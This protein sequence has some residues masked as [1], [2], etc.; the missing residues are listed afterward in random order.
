MGSAGGSETGHSG[1]AGGLGDSGGFVA[2]VGF[3]RRNRIAGGLDL[4]WPAGADGGSADDGADCSDF[5][6]PDAVPAEAEFGGKGALMTF[7]HA[8]VLLFCWV[9]ALWVFWEW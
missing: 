6:A 5:A 7:G 9:P 2:S 1:G 3:A 4:L 8:W